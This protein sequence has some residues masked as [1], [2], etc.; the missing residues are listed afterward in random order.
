MKLK[1]F[2]LILFVTI[3]IG[4]AF[5]IK[6]PVKSVQP[7][8]VLT[9]QC[10]LRPVKEIIF[11]EGFV[12]GEYSVKLSAPEKALIEAV[13]VQEGDAVVKG[14]AVAR[15][16]IEPTAFEA[17]KAKANLEF[18]KARFNDLDL[19][20][21]R[22]KK[23]YESNIISIDDYLEYKIAA[24]QAKSELIKAEKDLEMLNFKLE[25]EKVLAPVSGTV[26]KSHANPGE[27]VSDIITISV[28]KQFEATA[29]EIEAQNIYVGMPA[30]I[31]LN[32]R[33]GKFFSGKVKRIS[34]QINIKDHTL[35]VILSFDIIPDSL[36]E[37]ENGYCR[38][39]SERRVLT[40]PQSA[41]VNFSLD[42]ALVFVIENH[43]AKLRPIEFGVSDDGFTEVISGISEGEKVAVSELGKLNDG[44]PVIEITKN[45]R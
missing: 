2:L 29:D 1:I 30:E 5:Y 39:T 26:I 28:G 41:L 6:K 21:Q 42:Q 15:Y 3:S 18:A 22:R 40:V 27:R 25:E 35:T 12:T 33:I 19:R 16:K 31:H 13:L 38:M 14:Q 9:G 11:A 43:A 37:G 7:K 20:E 23:L 45:P 24:I 36:R 4:T 17:E 32:A 34:P 8:A 44:E 10:E